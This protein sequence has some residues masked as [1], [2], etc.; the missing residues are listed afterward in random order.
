MSVASLSD[1]TSGK[2]NVGLVLG[3][4]G[5]GGIVGD[6]IVSLVLDKSSYPTECVVGEV[7]ME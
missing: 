5:T 3:A 2:G 7:E 6:V 1:G 4:V